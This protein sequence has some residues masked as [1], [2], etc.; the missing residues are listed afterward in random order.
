MSSAAALKS[1]RLVSKKK[2]KKNSNQYKNWEFNLKKTIIPLALFM[3]LFVYHLI[4]W[5][6]VK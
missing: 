4:Q 5:A 6:L 3:L 1:F 2:N